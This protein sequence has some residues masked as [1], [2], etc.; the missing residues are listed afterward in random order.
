MAQIFTCLNIKIKIKNILHAVEFSLSLLVFGHWRESIS[1]LKI[2]WSTEKS[3]LKGSVISN[4][5]TM[6]YT[7]EEQCKNFYKKIKNKI[8]LKI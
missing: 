8:I 3:L 4:V 2:L 5:L 1:Q 6:K 7:F